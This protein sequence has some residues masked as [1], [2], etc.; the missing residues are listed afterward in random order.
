MKKLIAI[1]FV[2]GLVLASCAKKE[3]ATDSN[4]M[5]EEPEVTVTD[6]AKTV[7]TATAKPETAMVKDSTA[8]K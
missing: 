5:L 7:P 3:T 6:T 8:T 4:I 1:A 2:G